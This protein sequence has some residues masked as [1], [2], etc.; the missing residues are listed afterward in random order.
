MQYLAKSGVIIIMKVHVYWL[1]AL[2][3]WL[4][5][6]CSDDDSFTTSTSNQL[7][8][9]TDSVRL[10]TIFSRV[11]TAT[12]TFWVYNRS[13]D[14][15]RCANI[16]LQNGNQ[17]GFRVNVDGVYLG[18][19]QGYQVNDVEIR[20]KDSIRVFVELTSPMNMQEKPTFIKDDLIFTL[21]SGVEQ[22]VNL[23]A[24][25]W[26][27]E[28]W[29]DV[30]IDRDSLIASEKPIVIYGGLKVDEG[31]TL[32][33][34]AGT[35]LYFHN[36]A[37]IDVYGTLKAEGTSEKNVVLRGDRI[38]H[39]FDYLPYDRVSGQW[40]G[41][42]FHASSFDNELD[43]A[44]VHSAYNGIVCDS[45]KVDNLK[46]TLYNSL[47]HNCQGYGLLATSCVLDVY[48]TQITN[49]L[50]DCVAV[51][52]GAAMFRHCTIAQFYPFDA[53]RGMALRFA[54][55]R[56][57]DRLPLYQFE[58]YNTIV[59]GYADDVIMTDFRDDVEATY[60]F[61]HCLLRTPEVTE[62]TEN[63]K[64]VIWENPKD[65]VRC[66]IK[67]FRKMDTENLEYDFRL[68]GRSF[69]VDAGSVLLHGYS[70]YDRKAVRRDDKPD[71]GAYEWVEEEA[72]KE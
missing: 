30:E 52:G 61:D 32:T 41:I 12:K 47:I 60:L 17:T 72:T 70:E 29:H 57:E 18:A 66:G 64:E 16:R 42:R 68:D 50:N 11:P 7:T 46:L 63:I 3:F 15:I 24:Y 22:K 53:N 40:Q 20:D 5:A 4:L 38:D 49:T 25:T 48:N 19:A 2:S 8:F 62:A 6:S 28:L 35:T 44:D 69:A 21:E 55:Y 71:L 56:G 43:Y 13:G 59:T 58:V 23:N 33:L 14:G 9:S 10:D 31:A 65:T 26:D 1:I 27:A 51:Y 37:G 34:G 45:S 36:D 54:N 67:N 39:M